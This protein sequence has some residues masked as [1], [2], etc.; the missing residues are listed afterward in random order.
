MVK[1]KMQ[2]KTQRIQNN[3]TLVCLF[4]L[5]FIFTTSILVGYLRYSTNTFKESQTKIV[6]EHIKHIAKVD[7]VFYDMKTVILSCDSGTIQ[8]ASAL[9]CQLQKDSALFRR[10]IQLSQEE[11]NHLVSL[12]IDKIDN[13][14]SQIG[15]W[16]GILSVIF[17]IFGFFAIFKIEETKTEAKNV[18]KEVKEKGEQ[19]MIRI[20]ELQDQASRLSVSYNSI[21]QNANDFIANMATEIDELKKGMNTVQMESNDRLKRINKLLEDVENKNKQYNWSIETM[22]NQM[23]QQE[24]LTGMLKEII[25]KEVKEESY[26]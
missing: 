7:S 16:G 25:E 2:N 4:C 21:S 15:I 14:Y 3:T 18:L 5:A 22:K 12:H 26:E 20:N 9:L 24:E 1:D 19:A 8:N 10:E 6:N 17:L 23:K 11:M 13:D